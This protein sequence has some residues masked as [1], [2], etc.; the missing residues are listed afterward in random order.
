MFK[1]ELDSNYT[2]G[3]LLGLFNIDQSFISLIK[4][5]LNSFYKNHI[6]Y[7]EIT[8]EQLKKPK[9]KRIKESNSDELGMIALNWLEKFQYL[10]PGLIIQMFDITDSIIDVQ[11]VDINQISEPIIKNIQLIKN[12]YQQS[13]QLILIKNFK[14]VPGLENNMKNAIMKYFKYNFKE[15][16][17]YFINDMLYQNNVGIIQQIGKLIIDEVTNYYNYKIKIYIDKFNSQKNNEQKEYAIKYLIKIFL[18]AKITNIILDNKKINYYDYIKNAYEILKKIDKKNY[19]FSNNDLKVK[20]LEIKNLADFLLNQILSEKNSNRKNIFN[21][22]IN[23]LYYFDRSNIYRNDKNDISNNP[24]N[25]FKKA[26]DISFINNKWKYSWLQYLLQI[27]SKDNNLSNNKI[28]NYYLINNL[29]HIYIFLKK[30][31]NFLQ[32]INSKIDKGIVTKK[33]KPKFIE[34]VSKYYEMEGDNITG[35]INDEENFG[36]YISELVIENMN[37]LN[38]KYILTKIKDYFSNKNNEFNYY[39]FYLINKYCKDNESKIDFNHDLIKVLNA[40]SNNIF[41]FKN[42]FSH[43]SNKINKILLETKINE[44]ENSIL[45][46][47]LIEHLILFTSLSD[48]E[49]SKEQISKMN[50]VFSLDL[51]I[52]QDNKRIIYLK[53]LENKLFNLQ[54]NYNMKEVT[55]L[56]I[57]NITIDLSLLRKDL[58]FNIEKIIIYFP[59]NINNKEIMINKILSKDTPININFNYF[60]KNYFNKF[61]ITNIELHLKNKI[62]INLLNKDKKDIILYKQEKNKKNI[63]DIINIEFI[64]DNKNIKNKIILGKNENH[65]MNI[66]Y[67]IKSDNKDLII[68]K[69]KIIVQLLKDEKKVEIKNYEY[70]ILEGTQGYLINEK[71]ELI[72]ENV[73]TILDENLPQVE[74]IL[75]IKETG[76]FV[77]NYKF[78]FTLI[79]K[80]CPNEFCILDCNKNIEIKSIEPFIFTNE[81]KSPLYFINQKTQLKTYPINYAITLISFIE[82]ILSENIIIN[83]ILHLPNNDSLE[84]NSVTEKLFY[85]LKNYNIK[86]CPKDKISIKAQIKSKKEFSGSLGQLKIFWASENLFKNKNFNESYINYSIFDLDEINI[87]K[88]SLII[89]GKYLKM[90]NKY[91]IGIKNLDNNTKIIQCNIKEEN[92]D[93]KYILCGKTNLKKILSPN[94]EIQILYNIYDSFTGD[95][96][97]ENMENKIYQ[98]NCVFTINEYFISDDKDKFKSDYLNNIIYFSPELFKLT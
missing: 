81:L 72:Y 94:K 31:P 84:I 98:F 42:V 35:L 30:E 4:S 54:L 96:I 49:I 93:E 2:P 71:N 53:N 88:L 18:L 90:N 10:T 19:M 7:L 6:N 25:E 39:D 86:F 43:I 15:K 40:K 77:L 76:N 80:N 82:N 85:K 48:K 17:I 64:N 44:G 51:N 50:D 14:K 62:I 97:D 68:K 78:N 47:R 38:S 69:I 33:I 87:K 1:Y 70:K 20:Y 24:F 89:E 11:N 79:N 22:I 83:K 16:S 45:I 56:D 36:L 29:Y 9:L 3:V 75:K 23:H 52:Q 66:K 32:E 73:N 34:K 12:G 55:L 26:K 28:L 46:F 92:K 41:K 65:L 57:L 95:N 59:G 61:Y 58:S 74:Y 63:D 21:L 27:I 37:L 5:Y 60:I 13:N 8:D 67:N 91:Q